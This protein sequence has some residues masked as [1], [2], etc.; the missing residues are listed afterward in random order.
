MKR[1]QFGSSHFAVPIGMIVILEPMGD[2]TKIHLM[3]KS[4]I[5][6]VGTVDE[7]V[8]MVDAAESE[9]ENASN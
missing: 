7:I 5:Y 2:K 8:A 4:S 6:V 3:D 1:E 9:V